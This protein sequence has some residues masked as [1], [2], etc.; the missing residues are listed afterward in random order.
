[1]PLIPIHRRVTHFWPAFF[2][3][4]FLFCAF[5]ALVIIV[6][7]ASLPLEDTEQLRGDARVKKLAALRAEDEVKLNHFGW[8]NK[9]KGTVQIPIEHAME[10]VAAS[11]KDK[12]P[13]AS[14]VKVENPYPFG[15]QDVAAIP[16]SPVVS[17]A[18]AGG[19]KAAPSAAPAMTPAPATVTSPVVPASSGPN[20]ATSST[21]IL[22]ASKPSPPAPP[23]PGHN[24]LWNWE[25]PSPAPAGSPSPGAT[26]ASPS[27]TGTASPILKQ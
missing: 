1:M 2:G 25:S 3:G 21:Q 16:A 23:A 20:P 4:G 6:Y 19:P 14:S 8:I 9:E 17:G 22:P 11:L 12:A 26:T 18:A 27:A 7:R 15:L 13:H 24:H 10:L 5:A